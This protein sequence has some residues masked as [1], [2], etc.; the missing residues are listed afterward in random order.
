MAGDWIKMRTDLSEDPAVVLISD[1]MSIDEFGVVGRL[2]RVW[3]W[4]D[5]QSRNG[6]AARVTGAFVDRLTCAQGFAQAM[7]DA[8]WLVMD[9]TGLSIP[10]FDRHNGQTGKARTLARKRQ[11][12]FRVTQSSR[13]RN[14]AGVTKRREE[15]SINTPIVP[16]SKNHFAKPTLEEV[17]AY[18]IERKNAVDPQ[19]FLDHYESNGWRVGKN[20]MKD[21]R[22]A[23]RTWEKNHKQP[24]K[25]SRV[26]T[27]ADLVNWNPHDGGLGE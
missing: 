8:G 5:S 10:N 17:S 1:K 26:A 7:Q 13:K 15:K 18:C 14:A 21:W 2:H 3:S 16:S 22:A 12:R 24:E 25:R 9:D 19:S 11:E 4:F 27:D 20:P 23:V 6:N